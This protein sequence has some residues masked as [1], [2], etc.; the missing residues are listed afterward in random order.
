MKKVLFLLIVTAFIFSLFSFSALASSH[1]TDDVTIDLSNKFLVFTPNTEKS[2]FEKFK[3]AEAFINA[4]ENDKELLF[5]ATTDG[6]QSQLLGRKT[7]TEF[8][9]ET[10][11]LTGLTDETM[12]MLAE[13]IVI[14]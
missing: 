6:L 13:Q 14:I 10:E 5:I 4:F 11:T 9:K 1:T 2:E 12:R 3:G 8:S 7:Q